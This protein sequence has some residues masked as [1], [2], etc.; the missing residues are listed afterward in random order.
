VTGLYFL[1]ST[2]PERARNVRVSKR[3]ELEITSLL[4]SYLQEG[5]LTVRTMGR[6]YAWLDTGTHSSL[7][8][9]GVFV[10][11]LQERQGLQTG[12]PDEVAWRQGWISPGELA[13]RAQ[14]FGK[15]TYGSYLMALVQD[16]AAH[17]SR[18]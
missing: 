10:R 11:M 15:S 5:L 14:L 4:G 3:G 12:S 1:D 16:E 8:D 2:A 17:D 7:L 9:A 6:G 13:S 18:R